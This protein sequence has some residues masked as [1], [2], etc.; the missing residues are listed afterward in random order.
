MVRAIGAFPDGN[1]ALMPVYARLRHVTGTNRG[2]KRYLNM[3]HILE[4]DAEH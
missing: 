2:I 3:E 1:R 4:M